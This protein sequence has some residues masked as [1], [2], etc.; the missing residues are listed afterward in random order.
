[1]PFI[2]LED[3]KGFKKSHGWLDR[4]E[5]VIRIA[6]MTPPHYSYN[7]T[8]TIG[9]MMTIKAIQF[10]RDRELDSDVWLYKELD[11]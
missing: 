8:S 1:M 11:N 3:N 2:I 5:P 7:P 10:I 6:V 4:P 9:S